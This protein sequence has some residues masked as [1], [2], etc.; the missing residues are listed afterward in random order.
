[1]AAN[2]AEFLTSPFFVAPSCTSETTV[3]DTHKTPDADARRMM[4][5]FSVMSTIMGV[6]VMDTA[7]AGST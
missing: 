6:F 4:V 2:D 3:G 7:E 1:M 5:D